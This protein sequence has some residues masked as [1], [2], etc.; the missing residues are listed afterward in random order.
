MRLYL[1]EA[2]LWTA[3]KKAVADA[4]NRSGLPLVLFGKSPAV[5]PGFLGQLRVPVRFICDNN[6]SKWGSTLWGL[7]VISPTKLQDFYSE[8]NVLILV[9]FEHEIISQL[10]KLPVPPRNIFRLDL[11]FEEEDSA[12]FFQGV[13]ESIDWIYGKLADQK[14]KDTYESVIRY[15]VNRDPGYLRGISLPRRTQYFPDTLDGTPF[16]GLDEVFVD[17]GAF[18]GDTVE[19]FLAAAA[20]N[21]QAI[22]ALEPETDNFQKL[23]G[24][25]D[26]K[27]NFFCTQAAVGDEEKQ[28]CFSADDSGSK[29]DISGGEKVCVRTLDNLLRD[30]PVTFLKMDVEG[31]ESAALRGAK[32]LIQK[33]HPKLAIC[34]YHSNADMIEVPKLIMDLDPSYRLYVRH[35]TNALV[36][37]VCYAI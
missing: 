25:V 22:Y 18:I 12:N 32:R 6:P 37:T 15:R 16:L 10:K 29:A 33:N 27:P 7:E 20:G 36:E 8:Y 35:Y 1:D 30:V 3:R 19:N 17:A 11:Y 34:T 28:I 5:N 9:P 4:M 14:S 24:T 26:G 21:Y 2:Q 31:M 13:Q 23:L